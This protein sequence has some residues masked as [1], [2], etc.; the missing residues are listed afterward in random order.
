MDSLL[1]LKNLQTGEILRMRRVRDAAGQAVLDIDGSLPP[2]MSGP[3]L[4]VHFHQREEIVVKAGSLG[5]KVGGETIIV[6]AGGR[7]A[8]PAGVEHKWWNGG[9]DLLEVTGQ[10]IPAGDLDRYLQALFAILNASP[11]GRPSLFYI[12]HV[13]WRHRQTQ[14]V[15]VPPRSI[16]RIL[17]PLVLL[18]GHALGKYRGNAW[19][20]SP[21]SCTGA[22]EV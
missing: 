20:G 21:E 10:A 8:F 2:R 7:A 3:P 1:T 5:A 4:H 16:Q 9:E 22:P 12:A 6:P 18:L 15:G 17:F 14:S 13:L 19:P 11:S